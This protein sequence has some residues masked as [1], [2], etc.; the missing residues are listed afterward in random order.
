MWKNKALLRNHVRSHGLTPKA[1][2]TFAALL[3]SAGCSTYAGIE[4]VELV[5]ADG[6]T[7]L[8]ASGQ[9]VHVRSNEATSDQVT[10]DSFTCTY[11]FNA[12]GQRAS[13]LFE[14]LVALADANV[15][16]PAPAADVGN[17]HGEVVLSLVR[18]GGRETVWTLDASTLKSHPFWA[19]VV[20]EFE[21]ATGKALIDAF[22]TRQQAEQLAGGGWFWPA[23]RSYERAFAMLASWRD[24]RRA[25]SGADDARDT[26]V[27]TEPDLTNVPTDVHEKQTFSHYRELWDEKTGD[28]RIRSADSKTIITI[29]ERTKAGAATRTP[30]NPAAD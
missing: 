25:R 18:S 17:E 14:A 22:F 28:I 24:E 15:A 7:S 30:S 19:G 21:S 12:G 9:A 5:S 20:E 4:K 29:E 6:R 13:L 3:L 16:V 26:H 11:V 27:V 2:C 1:L 8:D 10:T 23:N